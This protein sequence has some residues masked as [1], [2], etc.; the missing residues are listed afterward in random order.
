MS[1]S[2][3]VVPSLT[4]CVISLALLLLI[5]ELPNLTRVFTSSVFLSSISDWF[6]KA[7]FGKCFLCYFLL[8]RKVCRKVVKKYE[9]L[10]KSCM[11]CQ[12][13]K[14]NRKIGY[15]KNLN[16][17]L[18]RYMYGFS[19]NLDQGRKFPYVCRAYNNKCGSKFCREVFHLGCMLWICRLYGWLLFV[20]VNRAMELDYRLSTHNT[21]TPR[22]TNEPWG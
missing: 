7:L 9:M 2:F 18:R 16:L 10:K 12:L 1:S 21:S 19:P 5:F 11:L 15:N 13:L 3:V 4:L 17:N 8:L 22:S 14:K 20:D 6:N